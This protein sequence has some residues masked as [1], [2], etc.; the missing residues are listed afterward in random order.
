MLRLCARK[1][2]LA[3]PRIELV[4]QVTAVALQG[5]DAEIGDSFDTAFVAP[6]RQQVEPVTVGVDAALG[7]VRHLQF[8]QEAI[9]GDSDR[10]SAKVL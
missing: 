2:L 3:A 4:E 9:D 10:G 6:G 8:H 7:I 5:F 1:Q